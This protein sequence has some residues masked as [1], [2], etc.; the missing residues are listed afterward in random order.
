M[1]DYSGEDLSLVFKTKFIKLILPVVIVINSYPSVIT[2]EDFKIDVTIS[3][4][5]PATNYLRIE[6][7]KDGTTNYFGETFNGS[8]WYGGADGL[9]YFPV[10]INGTTSAQIKGRVGDFVDSGDYKLKVKRYTQSGNAASD[11]IDPVDVKINLATSTPTPS[12]SPIASII[13]PLSSTPESTR[14]PTPLVMP[15]NSTSTPTPM[16]TLEV[17]K[18]EI[19]NESFPVLPALIFGLG[20]FCIGVSFYPFVHKVINQY[21]G[22]DVPGSKKVL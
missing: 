12:P 4:A 3:G 9:S 5:R 11:T 22:K 15:A 1:D 20:L 17:E 10:M 2:N 16:A 14:R 8:S 7:Y 18:G 13:L 19:K 21:N 6:I